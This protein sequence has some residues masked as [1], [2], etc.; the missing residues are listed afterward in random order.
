M[1]KQVPGLAVLILIAGVL[2]GG[3]FTAFLYD[4]Q[5]KDA[6]QA[7]ETAQAQRDLWR[8]KYEDLERRGEVNADRPA[9]PVVA[10]APSWRLS[11]PRTAALAAALLVVVLVALVL[12]PLPRRTSKAATT[13]VA[14]ARSG[15]LPVLAPPPNPRPMTDPTPPPPPIKTNDVAKALGVSNQRALIL[16]QWSRV[17]SFEL[18]E[19]AALWVGESPPLQYVVPLTGAA[20]ASFAR[21]KGA[22]LDGELIAEPPQGIAAFSHLTGRQV[23]ERTRV[24]RAN[25]IE[26]A[27]AQGEKP[28]FL[29]PGG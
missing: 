29:F 3:A 11:W 17:G 8:D 1:I 7:V 24:T 15:T 16:K 2:G 10:V 5:L 18:F 6:Q 27:K 23:D 9:K 14:N 20:Q 28:P 25:L 21:L 13:A 12:A 4:R 19:A 22:I 26:Y